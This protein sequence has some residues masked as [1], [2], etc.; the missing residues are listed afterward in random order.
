MSLFAS[1]SIVDKVRLSIFTTAVVAVVT[2]GAFVITS[3]FAM[4]RDN[5]IDNIASVA[6]VVSIN[7]AAP[8]VFNDE[9]EASR[10][11]SSLAAVKGVRQGVIFDRQ[12]RVFARFG[13]SGDDPLGHESFRHMDSG[14][15]QATGGTLLVSVPVLLQGEQIATL[16]ISAS[17]EEIYERLRFQSLFLFS[18]LM[19]SMAVAF[20]S[21]SRMQKFITEPI[22]SLITAMRK[23][24]HSGAYSLRLEKFNEDEIGELVDGFN[25]MLE[26]IHARDEQLAQAND[27]LESEVK[28]RT[29]QL[30]DINSELTTSLDEVKNA[31]DRAETANKAKGAFLATMSHEIRTPING[32][33]GNTELLLNEDLGDRARQ[34]GEVAYQSGEA[35]LDI[36]NDIL[37]FSRI[38]A[39]KLDLNE[40]P[41]RLDQVI[42]ELC[43][44]LSPAISDK[45]L[46]LTV[47]L[48]SAPV[49]ILLGDHG[50]LRQVVSNLMTNA[51]KFTAQGVITVSAVDISTKAD[52]VRTRIT[53]NDTG[54][55]I[56]EAQQ[57][58]VFDRFEQVDNTFERTAGGT[59][60][61]LAICKE[62]ITRMGGEIGVLSAPGEGSTFWLE[63]PFKRSTG[64][65]QLT[66]TSLPSRTIA[67]G[68]S[69]TA[70]VVDDSEINRDMALNMLNKIGC[71]TQV[72]VNGQEAIDKAAGESYELILMDCSMPEIDGFRATRRIRAAEIESGKAPAFIV[73]L[74]ANA[75][76]GD[77]ERCLQAGMSEYLAK[78]FKMDDL[79]ALVATVV[80]RRPEGIDH[81]SVEEQRQVLN[82]NA[83]ANIRHLESEGSRDLLARY[84]SIY[85]ANTPELLRSMC[86][87]HED[88]DMAALSFA[89]HSLKGE[90][91]SI[92]ADRLS[93]TAADIEQQI[94]CGKPGDIDNL[95]KEAHQ[96]FCEVAR[97]LQV[98]RCQAS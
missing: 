49:Q 6:D 9:A 30:E 64:Q 34:Y 16:G 60:L 19:V 69:C 29:L 43:V 48:S 72:A 86:S 45:Q 74:T 91:A 11:L 46:K 68:E 15:V 93:Q 66:N 8:V 85:Q 52:V 20:L 58:A 55:G 89:A 53:V 82:P 63:I 21:G 90:S 75:I 24:T 80:A 33:L 40:K 47:D 62:L 87:S 76:K 23:V 2:S 7:V 92:G 38:E 79:R 51:M 61:G 10:T 31:K 39:G 57:P 26:Q 50:R 78:P 5:F 97:A 94:A 77:R 54:I 70:L 18:I 25:E 37:D 44:S 96:E 1:R 36:I 59:G 3:E 95:L 13:E 56:P 4:F 67:H 22:D 14:K 73:A 27:E 42:E 17:F 65:M 98:G 41:F 88:N 35:L 32:L 84:V 12:G 81:K 28:A 83:I 71:E